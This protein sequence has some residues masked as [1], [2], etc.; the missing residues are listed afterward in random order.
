MPAMDP[1]A[2]EFYADYV[3]RHTTF[4]RAGTIIAIVLAGVW[5]LR[6]SGGLVLWGTSPSVV[7]CPPPGQCVSSP[8][9]SLAG[10]VVFAAV[11]G[12]IVGS[13]LAESY[14]LRPVRGPREASLDARPGRPLPRQ[15]RAAWLITAASVVLAGIDGASIRAPGLA[16]GLVPGL[17]AVVLA[18]AIQQALANRRR[19]IPDDQTM[20]VDRVLRA[21]VTRSAVWMQLSAAI[22]CLGWTAMGAA[23]DLSAAQASRPWDAVAGALM[24][25]GFLAVI[26][27]LVCIHRGA[28]A[29]VH[30]LPMRRPAGIPGSLA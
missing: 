25:G 15:T 6:W 26:P 24:A 9:R 2:Q 17:A 1:D 12:A 7:D 27:A 28:L 16:I 30:W 11:L 13:L 4:R 22:L 18:Q 21:A 29:P 3:G 23:S 14:H 5:S 19:P 10:T 20:L 8:S